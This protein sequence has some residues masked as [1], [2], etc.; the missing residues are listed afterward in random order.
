MRPVRLVLDGFASFRERT[1]VDFT[2]AE[3]FAL[4]GPTGSG[5]STVIDAITFAL[6][7]SVPRWDNQR[8]VSLALAPTAGRGTVT[9]VFDV[10]GA[11]YVAARE[12]RRAASGAV[13]VR[14]ARL[15]RLR[16]P[17]AVGGV[18]DETEP[19]AD[20]AG[21]V[22]AAVEELLGLPFGDFTT[23]VV[24]PQGD[25]AEFLHTEPRKRQEKLVRILGLGLYDQIAR[26]ANSEA[27]AARQ[28]ADVLGEQLA[29]YA[30]ATA[31]AEVDA[32]ERVDALVALAGR[33]DA[34]V[35][36]VEAA[37]AEQAAAEADATRIRAEGTVLAAL[38]APDDLAGLDARRAGAA[39]ALTAA[40]TAHAEAEEADTAA[41]DALAAAPERGP[42]ELVRARHAELASLTA[43]LPGLRD[44]HAK[45]LAAYDTAARDAADART[46][47]D[48][49]RAA[50]DA[51][52]S[53]AAT[54]A[55]AVRRLVGERDGL[56]ALAVP[57]G[58]D[59]LGR[60]RS[61]A[62]A[63]LAAADAALA[64]A[65]AADTRA[66]D[67]LDAAPARAPLEQARREHAER[68]TLL[69]EQEAAAASLAAA[70][71]AAAEA[72]GRTRAARHALEHAEARRAEVQRADVAATLRPALAV[73]EPCPVCA[74][75][76]AT[77][78]PPGAPTDPGAEQA[79]ADAA[80]AHDAARAQE[81]AAAAALARATAEH[82]RLDAALARLR[83]EP[84]AATAER[85]LAR[86]DEAERAVREADTA[87]RAARREREA[88]A[89]EVDTVR[90]DAAGAAAAL[91]TARD[92]LVPF[93][94]PA[95]PDDDVLAGWTALVAWAAEQAEARD[96]A[97][98]SARAAV[99]AADGESD[100]A[101]R[102]L[103]A[104]D[105]AAT[106]RRAE[107]TAAA[108]AEQ[109]ARGAVDGV[110]VRLAE[111]RTALDG[112]PSDADAARDLA[113]RSVL[114]DAARTSDAALRTARAAQRAA[115][116]DAAQVAD[117]VA[118]AWAA[119]RT[120]RDP[121]VPLGA[122][123]VT[124]DDLGAAW[125]ALVGWAS[126]AVADR[127]TRWTAAD[128]AARAAR[129]ARDAA[130]GELVDDLAAHGLAAHHL[131]LPRAEPAPAGPRGA[132]GAG[133]AR[134]S[135]SDPAAARSVVAAAVERA[136]GAHA[137]LAER[138]ATAERIAADRDAA[139]ESQQVAKMLGGL[140]R[141]D[142][143][144]RWLVASALDALVADASTSLAELSGGQF[145]LTHDH[146][147]FLV[148]DHAD[149]DARRPVKTL[150]GGETF[151]ASLALALALS[152]QMSGLAARGA[153]RL[154]SIF[155]DEGFGTLDEA[156]LEV[157]AST[158]ENLAA[159]G[160]R[161][162]GVVTHV[163]ALA[164]RVPVR[165]RVG[166]DQRTSSV[167]REDL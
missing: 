14:S 68:R 33:V 48:A 116:R 39:A 139:E 9:L 147:E 18:D 123:A 79:V 59:A 126:D 97:L 60:R 70:E 78:P 124:G 152:A 6:Y 31:E 20:G 107:E 164:E 157:V 61:A 137:R 26:E 154:E 141:S 1:V 81:A 96:A 135:E 77:L 3:Y 109:E 159:R 16:D 95:V 5:K 43:D 161:M 89:R 27:S 114:E 103:H 163:P 15:E 80:T 149:A 44:R 65:E 130:V 83:P 42:L 121:L 125:A 46:A 49:A 57:A 41:R 62:V 101:G 88:E 84:D 162:V 29:G 87:V 105:R 153:A 113:R 11:R 66:R 144:P 72:A 104:A 93:G 150:S 145:A 7:G 132:A 50:R 102:A 74:Q 92:P 17:S 166:R 118:A 19:L 155:L 67:A 140:L 54:A 24:L 2:G 106:E 167:T 86:L 23:C 73:G 133:N 47:L 12:L 143:F 71:Q 148:I 136:R 38:G 56:R 120:A 21:G 58:L 45:S 30:D 75:A 28:R 76:V 13:S 52:A 22:T 34:L 82:E 127:R 98:A 85:E 91:R 35:P 10:G 156:N 55:E 53:A 111:L 94:A 64:A 158:L 108:R 25:F 40:G 51:A 90:A 32:Q 151:Q 69:R 112:A 37:A 122:P 165:F 36:Q 100:A 142:G 117:E 134:G 146:G 160:D 99:A 63:A 128:A 138:R 110:Q 131:A 115:E 4:V 129:E 119:L 8:T